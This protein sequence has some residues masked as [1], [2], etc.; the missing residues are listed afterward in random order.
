MKLL[1]RRHAPP[2]TPVQA[3]V[4]SGEGR[5]AHLMLDGVLLCPFGPAEGDRKG[6]GSDGEREFAAI[7]PT[8]RLCATALA[9]VGVTP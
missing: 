5:K 9:D 8:C 2:P 3:R 1:R 6:L 4:Y 7:L